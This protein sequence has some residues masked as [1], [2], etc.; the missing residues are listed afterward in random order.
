MRK[1]LI[2][3]LVV[4][5]SA[6]LLALTG[7]SAPAEPAADEPSTS[8]SQAPSPAESS[9]APEPAAGDQTVEESCAVAQEAMSSLQT[10]M[11]GALESLG[12][13]DIASVIPAL[14]SF[15]T[16]LG[17]AVS[18]VSNPEVGAA[19]SAFQTDFASF[20][21]IIAAAKDGGMETIDQTAL[22]A[23]AGELQT[24]AQDV[25]ALCS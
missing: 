8:T 20:N 3:T 1:P 15:E 18:Q 4:L 10:E 11:T 7:C 24:S 5:A 2:P 22:Q 21:D 16:Q 9:A 23:A 25:Q 17:E 19:L 12:S 14:E 6:G 13:G